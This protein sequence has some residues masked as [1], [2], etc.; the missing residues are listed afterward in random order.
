MPRL[1]LILFFSMVFG[2]ETSAQKAESLPVETLSEDHFQQQF[3]LVDQLP[4]RLAT[5]TTPPNGAVRPMA[6]WEEI[7]AIIISWHAYTTA[8]SEIVRHAQKECKVYINCLG[9][10]S[11]VKEDLDERGVSYGANV[12]FLENQDFN[13]VWIRDYGPNSAY[14]N[15]VDSLI[16]VDWVYNR[17]TRPADDALPEQIANIL[18][19]PIYET[20]EG[21]FKLTATGGNFMTDGIETGF[22]SSLVINENL[23]KTEEEI[24]DIMSEFLG[25]K[26][27]IKFDTL[28]YDGIHHIDMHM[29]LLDEER[30]M[31]GQYP[32]GKGDHDI[33]EANIEYL[34]ATQKMLLASPTK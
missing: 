5:I 20:A 34:L 25:V 30:I 28:D 27:Y 1:Y 17:E 8:L 33:I 10:A 7:E 9:P 26:N 23:D 4:K 31:F 16:M 2:L 3:V 21:D 29:K 6:E 24:D 22:S 19:V 12:I 15:D 14:T 32:E 18:D 11:E 13:S